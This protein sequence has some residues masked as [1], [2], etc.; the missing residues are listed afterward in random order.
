MHDLDYRL[1]FATV[2]T[3]LLH[4]II[5][6][7]PIERFCVLCALTVI[8]QCLQALKDDWDDSL[9]GQGSVTTDSSVGTKRCKALLSSF[10]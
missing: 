5:L 10:R 9:P 1:T 3:L 4:N 8:L 2:H 6:I 7:V